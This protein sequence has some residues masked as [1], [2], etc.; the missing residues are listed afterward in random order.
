MEK[1]AKNYDYYYCLAQAN[2]NWAY[3]FLV[4]NFR[5]NL[6]YFLFYEDFAGN[7]INLMPKIKA[8]KMNLF[9]NKLQ[10]VRLKKFLA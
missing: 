10:R 9:C 2:R 4:E 1:V 3:S 8:E 7:N 5:N 6:E